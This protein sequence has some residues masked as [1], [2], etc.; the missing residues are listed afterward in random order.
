MCILIQLCAR[1]KKCSDFFKNDPYSLRM[2][3]KDVIL[4]WKRKE[5]TELAECL[6]HCFLCQHESSFTLEPLAE[7]LYDIIDV[8]MQ[9]L[10]EK[11]RL[12]SFQYGSFSM[13]IF[14]QISKLPES[15]NFIKQ[16]M[17]K[18]F[19]KV[20]LDYLETINLEESAFDNQFLQN[21]DTIP[22]D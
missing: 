3:I 4:N 5:Q 16:T 21:Y 15:Q 19:E 6:V 8:D 14:D 17:G 1:L 10:S 18:I 11:G 2:I 12:D 13:K 9:I 20:D 7:R 22:E